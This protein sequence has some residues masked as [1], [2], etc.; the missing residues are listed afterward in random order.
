MIILTKE[1][2]DGFTQ[3]NNSIVQF[4]A[5]WCGP[6]KA[7][8]VTLGNMAVDVQIGKLDID[9][10]TDIAAK[11]NIR[12]VP[13]LVFFKNGQEVDRMMGAKPAQKIKEFIDKNKD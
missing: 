13:T 12:S 10:A 2:F 4:S 7:L 9:D 5:T 11:F 6:C 3:Q 8:S 1:S